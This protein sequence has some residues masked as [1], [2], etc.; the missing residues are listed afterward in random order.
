MVFHWSWNT[1]QDTL[2][3]PTR[4]PQSLEGLISCYNPT[5]TRLSLLASCC[6]SSGPSSF[7]PQGSHTCYSLCW[8]C[9]SWLFTCLTSCSS[10]RLCLKYYIDGGTPLINSSLSPNWSMSWV[11]YS[12][13]TP[14]FFSA[15]APIWNTILSYVMI[16]NRC[17]LHE[18]S[19]SWEEDVSVLF[20]I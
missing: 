17:L 16:F 11:T 6:S 13:G 4:D 8:E 19:T 1:T 15:N 2:A 18:P 5:H 7:P 3:K 14:L 10:L 12:H 9:S 20:T